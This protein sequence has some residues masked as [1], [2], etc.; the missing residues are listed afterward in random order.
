MKKL[1]LSFG[2]FFVVQASSETL[3][4]PRCSASVNAN[5]G[6]CSN[7]GENVYQ[8]HKCRFSA[9][10]FVSA[11]NFNFVAEHVGVDFISRQ[12]II[13]HYSYLDLLFPSACLAVCSLRVFYSLVFVAVVVVVFVIFVVVIVV[14]EV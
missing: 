10:F 5:P 11:F 1:N 2:F 8:C 13:P 9:C 12:T 14:F 3:Q 4:C 7:C 6:V